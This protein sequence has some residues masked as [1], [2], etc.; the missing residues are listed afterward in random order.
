M[1]RVD[2]DLVIALSQINFAK[3]CC[4]LQPEQQIFYAWYQDFVENCILIDT[5]VVYAH[6][7]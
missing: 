6:V 1:A 5:T 2:F 7:H 3:Y 4:A